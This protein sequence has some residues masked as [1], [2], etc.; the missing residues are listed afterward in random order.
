MPI[1]SLMQ[2]HLRNARVLASIAVIEAAPSCSSMKEC[3]PSRGPS[4]RMSRP[5]NGPSTWL[6]Q[7]MRASVNSPA[8]PGRDTAPRSDGMAVDHSPSKR[9]ITFCDDGATLTKPEFVSMTTPLTIPRG[10]KCTICALGAS[11]FCGVYAGRL[12]GCSP[13]ALSL[14]MSIA[15][16][17]GSVA[18][19]S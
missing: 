5:R 17:E 2:R 9:S 10:G 19:S 13:I 11:A 14:G 1:T 8:C 3:A 4:S 7:V 15:P 6:A 18:R 12:H 16:C